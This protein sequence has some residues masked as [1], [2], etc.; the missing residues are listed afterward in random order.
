MT[1]S[2]RSLLSVLASLPFLGFLKPGDGSVK[3]QVELQDEHKDPEGLI[4][5]AWGIIANV[6]NGDWTKQNKDWQQAAALWRNT[7]HNHLDNQPTILSTQA[8]LHT[9]WNATKE[10]IEKEGPYADYVAWVR[11]MNERMKRPEFDS[12]TA[13]WDDMGELERIPFYCAMTE[14]CCQAF[15]NPQ[16]APIEYCQEPVA[17]VLYTQDCC[18][19][20]SPQKM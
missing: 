14:C 2:R 10:D 11:W 20:T 8:Y 5:W 17:E 4:H 3:V 19:T 18:P 12:A 7:Y 1:T 16:I 6:S 15:Y 9:P 13:V